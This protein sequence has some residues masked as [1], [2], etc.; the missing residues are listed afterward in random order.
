VVD[1]YIGYLRSKIERQGKPNLIHTVRGR[2][3]VLG[4]QI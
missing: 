3:Y 4:A 2:G 1:V